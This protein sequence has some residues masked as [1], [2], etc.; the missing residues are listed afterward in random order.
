MVFADVLVTKTNSFSYAA[1][2]IST[3]NIYCIPFWHPPLPSWI[4]MQF[5]FF[6]REKHSQSQFKNFKK[7]AA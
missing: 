5:K 2:L 1:G 6:D 4:C 7:I 3:G